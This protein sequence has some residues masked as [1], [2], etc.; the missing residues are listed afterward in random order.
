MILAGVVPTMSVGIR[1]GSLVSSVLIVDH[2]RTISYLF[3]FHNFSI[4]Q[5]V[6]WVV[7]PDRARLIAD[8]LV[9]AILMNVALYFVVAGLAMNVRLRSCH[10]SLTNQAITLTLSYPL[11]LL[12]L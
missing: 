5:R 9:I 1:A 11:P 3:V 6:N 4:T 10:W 12:S 8:P 2:S 7:Y